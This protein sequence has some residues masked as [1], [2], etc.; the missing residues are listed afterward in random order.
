MDTTETL[1]KLTYWTEHIKDSE[2][3]LTHNTAARIELIRQAL[4]HEVKVTLIM[5]ATG[6]TKSRIYQIKRGD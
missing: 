4:E 3:A 5:A 6:L 2:D 1:N